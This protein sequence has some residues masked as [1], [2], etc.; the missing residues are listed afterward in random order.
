MVL[1][2]SVRVSSSCFPSFPDREFAEETLH[3]LTIACGGFY[4]EQRH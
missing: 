1:I 3:P 2:T 4:M